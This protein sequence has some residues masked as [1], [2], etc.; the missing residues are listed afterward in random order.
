MGLLIGIVGF[1]LLFIY[2]ANQIL[3]RKSFLKTFFTSGFVCI[4]TATFIMALDGLSVIHVLSSSFFVGVFC[5]IIFF[6]LLIY[7]LFF[8]IP[9]TASYVEQFQQRS[10]Y[11]QKMY[12]LSRH[13]G[14]LWFIGVYWSLVLLFPTQ[15]MIVLAVVLSTLNLVYVLIQDVWSFPKLFVDYQQYKN[16]TPFLIPSIKSIL[17]TIQSYQG[18]K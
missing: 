10:V 13:P 15:S 8:S 17:K 14:V 2:E 4:I 12:A 18:R 9:F 1:V 16:T 6:V 3:W 5:F 11:T 7:T